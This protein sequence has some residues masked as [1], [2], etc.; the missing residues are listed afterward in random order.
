MHTHEALT[1]SRPCFERKSCICAHD[2]TCHVAQASKRHFL[3]LL[4]L[5]YSSPLF[6]LPT[7]A[8]IKEQL[9]FHNT[10]PQQVCG[11]RSKP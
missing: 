10:G 4:R 3:E 11:D 9:R 2:F 7:A 5:R 6:R 8:H 1:K